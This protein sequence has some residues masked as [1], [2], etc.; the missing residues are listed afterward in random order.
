MVF[1]VQKQLSDSNASNEI[2]ETEN[3]LAGLRKTVFIPL[4]TPK[5]S[6]YISTKS[7]KTIAATISLAAG[8]ATTAITV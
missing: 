3:S 8:I 4:N 7:F 5:Y 2:E 6:I 1:S